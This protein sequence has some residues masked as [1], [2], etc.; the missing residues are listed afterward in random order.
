[1]L[2]SK[3]KQLV[4]Y[5]PAELALDSE[6]LTK[7]V[8]VQAKYIDEL[9]ELYSVTLPVVKLPIQGFEVKGI[10]ALKKIE[11]LLYPEV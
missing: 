1:M 6:L 8:Q 9:D 3:E 5:I 4:R 2:N 11:K 7:R 10:D